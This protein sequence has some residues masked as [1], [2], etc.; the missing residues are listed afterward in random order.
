[1]PAYACP[2]LV[3]A[4]LHAG[5]SPVLVDVGEN[6]PFLPCDE[7]LR[8]ISAFTVAIVAINFMGLHEDTAQL[9]KICEQHGL[10][11]IYDCAQWFPLN[12]KC[13]WP[14]DFNIISFGR[15]KAINL[16]HGGAVIVNDSAYEKALPDLVDAKGST[17]FN[18]I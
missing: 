16:L 4:A 8:N 13:N 10:F 5:A 3:S 17:I 7:I 12:K 15:G 11:L 1:M 9:R 14:G 2:D 6:S 18:L